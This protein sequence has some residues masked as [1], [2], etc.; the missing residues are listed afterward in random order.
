M[1]TYSPEGSEVVRI[2][3]SLSLCEDSGAAEVK[4]HTLVMSVLDT[5]TP[6]LTQSQ[7]MQFQSREFLKKSK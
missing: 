7:V 6:R 3:L 4:L 5:D 1:L 2:N